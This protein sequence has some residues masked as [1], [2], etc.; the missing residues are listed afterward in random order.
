MNWYETNHCKSKAHCGTCRTDAGW[1]AN[2]ANI[3]TFQI[4][5]TV[6]DD[7]DFPC[8][9]DY[10]P[11]TLPEPAKGETWITV[12]AHIK[13]M[14]WSDMEQAIAGLPPAEAATGRQRLKVERGMIDMPGC[15][16]CTEGA[17][18]ARMRVWLTQQE[19]ELVTA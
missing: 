5:R 19:K 17:A 6:F 10:T 15:T 3:F 8:P 18:L 14:G 9:H 13:A 16:Q 1:R 11:D 12:P 2:M 4:G 7:A